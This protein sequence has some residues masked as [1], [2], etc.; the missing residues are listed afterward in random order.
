M[1]IG[2]TY[3]QLLK[4]AFEPYKTVEDRSL[5][6]T[7]QGRALVDALAAIRDDLSGLEQQL[8][9]ISRHTEDAAKELEQELDVDSDAARRFESA[10]ALVSHRKNRVFAELQK[11]ASQEHTHKS[12]ELD[13]DGARQE[14]GADS[15]GSTHE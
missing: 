3:T 2:G 8:I 9:D 12:T 6:E 1:A 13:K 10:Y 15:Q 14:V 7:L 5:R 11:L 4:D